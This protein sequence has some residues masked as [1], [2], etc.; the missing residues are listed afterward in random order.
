MRKLS[1][2][3]IILLLIGVGVAS[4][5]VKAPVYQNTIV[6]D[7]HGTITQHPS[8]VKRVRYGDEGIYKEK[9]A[10]GLVVMWDLTSNDA[11]TVS[12]ITTTTDRAC[13][14]LVTELLTQDSGGQGDLNDDNYGYM[15]VRGY[16]LAKMD[17]SEAG[18]GAEG[19]RLIPSPSTT[20][21]NAGM[22]AAWGLNVTST[23]NTISQD[24]GT[25]LQDPTADGL[26]PVILN[27]M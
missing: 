8:W 2:L 25:L 17:F 20:V 19:N 9:L 22:F 6:I 16:C 4:A 13:G 1:L 23:E 12:A 10:S 18:T 21:A 26:F 3:I 24:C 27:I 15:C 11:I 7:G 14:V 5:D